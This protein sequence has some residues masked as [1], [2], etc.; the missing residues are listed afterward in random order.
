VKKELIRLGYECPDLRDHI[1]PILNAL[2]SKTSARRIVIDPAILDQ[3]ERA[4]LDS[5]KKNLRRPHTK[6]TNLFAQYMT[7]VMIHPEPATVVT[8]KSVSGNVQRIPIHWGIHPQSNG[9]IDSRGR[10]V[11]LINS[12]KIWKEALTDFELNL[13]EHLEHEFTHLSEH[14]FVENLTKRG[15]Q[16][17]SDLKAYYNDPYEIRA[18]LGELFR[19]TRE[20]VLKAVGRGQALGQALLEAL[21]RN[22]RWNQMEPYL[23]RKNKNH[24]LKGLTTSFQ[25][26][27][28]AND[29]D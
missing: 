21:A 8:L 1:R 15:P 18:Y 25:D 12:R 28:E 13:R 6:R 24:L 27:L 10:L 16:D 5:V 29:R 2:T 3:A 9:F 11:V 22:E 23:E 19:Q 26:E 17:P 4:V 14:N 20:D 7:D